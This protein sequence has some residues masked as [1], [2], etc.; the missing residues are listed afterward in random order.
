MVDD[1]REEVEALLRA[2]FAE[3]DRP[4]ALSVE[5]AKALF[6]LRRIDD[7]L[8]DLIERSVAVRADGED[9][10]GDPDVLR[11]EHAG[12]TL[13]V[14]R[15]PDRAELIVTPPTTR[16]RLESADGSTPIEVDEAGVGTVPASGPARFR[17]TLPDGSSAVTDGIDLR[18]A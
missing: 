16:V 1:T 2:H 11:F 18:P 10:A 15:R 17:I 4:S 12:V 8:M 3:H 5:T 13:V 14:R 6:D 9:D 7:E